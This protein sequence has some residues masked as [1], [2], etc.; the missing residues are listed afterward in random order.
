M[1]VLHLMTSG[2]KLISNLDKLTYVLIACI[3]I[4]MVNYALSFRTSPPVVYI[5]SEERQEVISRVSTLRYPVLNH[6]TIV[7]NV[8]KALFD[9][10]NFDAS[11]YSEQ[12][13][14][15]LNKWYTTEGGIDVFNNITRLNN[16]GG[17]FIDSMVRNRIT[18]QAYVL[19]GTAVI[20]STIVNGR[21]AWHVGARLMLTYR[22]ELGY[23]STSI[24]DVS[25]WV[26]AIAPSINPNALAIMSI[27]LI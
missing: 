26:T 7:Q 21:T 9:T 13:T 22:N 25:V 8:D 16:S 3:L 4:G 12:L 24:V 10:F 18:S 23:S 1:K 14:Y 2:K 6:A 17:S 15:A 20:R 19:P 5:Y 11:N 27:R